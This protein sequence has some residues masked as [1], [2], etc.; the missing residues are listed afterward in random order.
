M[1]IGVPF[2]SSSRKITHLDIANNQD[3]PVFFVKLYEASKN[4]TVTSTQAKSLWDYLEQLSNKDVFQKGAFGLSD[5]PKILE[6]IMP[7]MRDAIIES[8]KV[9]GQILNNDNSKTSHELLFFV[10]AYFNEM[11]ILTPKDVLAFAT[12]SGIDFAK[13]IDTFEPRYMDVSKIKT[14]INKPVWNIIEWLKGMLRSNHL[15]VHDV[16]AT[17][18]G[19]TM[20]KLSFK[21]HGLCN[22][23]LKDFKEPNVPLEKVKEVAV[24]LSKQEGIPKENQKKLREALKQLETLE[25]NPPVGTIDIWTI[26]AIMRQMYFDEEID[27]N[28]ANTLVFQRTG[29]SLDDYFEQL[30]LVFSLIKTEIWLA[31]IAYASTPSLE[32]QTLMSYIAQYASI[33]MRGAWWWQRKADDDDK[34][35]GKKKDEGKGKEEATAE[36]LE[37]EKRKEA[38]RREEAEIAHL[39]HLVKLK[40]KREAAIEEVMRAD[41]DNPYNPELTNEV[42]IEE[43]RKRVKKRMDDALERIGDELMVLGQTKQL[44]ANSNMV[45]RINAGNVAIQQFKGSPEHRMAITEALTVVDQ[46]L[47][48]NEETINERLRPLRFEIDLYQAI[49]DT[50]DRRLESINTK[51]FRT[52]VRLGTIMILIAGVFYVLYFIRTSDVAWQKEVFTTLDKMKLAAEKTYTRGLIRMWENI[53]Q[54]SYERVRNNSLLGGYTPVSWIPE[55]NMSPDILKNVYEE[56][57]RRLST[58]VNE[59]PNPIDTTRESLLL[60]VNKYINFVTP[61]YQGLI[62]LK[63]ETLTHIA[64]LQQLGHSLENSA[65]LQKAQSLL[66]LIQEALSKYDDVLKLQS[67]KNISYDVI[68]KTVSLANNAFSTAIETLQVKMMTGSLPESVNLYTRVTSGLLQLPATTFHFCHSMIQTAIQKVQGLNPQ[69]YDLTPDRML[70]IV[71]AGR[72]PEWLENYQN[73]GKAVIAIG[74]ATAAIPLLAL[75]H[76]SNFISRLYHTGMDPTKLTNAAYFDAVSGLTILWVAVFEVLQRASVGNY[77][78]F[79]SF[80][81]GFVAILSFIFPSFGIWQ[82][83]TQKVREKIGAA[84]AVQRGEP[85]SLQPTPNATPQ[86]NQKPRSTPQ[87]NSE[88]TTVN[89]DIFNIPQQRR[90]EPATLNPAELQDATTRWLE[91]LRQQQQPQ[92]SARVYVIEDEEE[93]EKTEPEK[94]VESFVQCHIC[95]NEAR[96]MCSHCYDRSYCGADCGKIDWSFDQNKHLSLPK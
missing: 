16:F 63:A 33:G 9:L 76:V 64:K 32:R 77:A 89:P 7:L 31:I 73:V 3:I 85:Q 93:T 46:L 74:V 96:F 67:V 84:K 48:E 61:Y 43:T 95:G 69:P 25:K 42:V 87:L 83:V 35:K 49:L 26:A 72:S 94:K 75:F 79:W 2:S 57:L 23:F 71:G 28:T 54:S 41:P 80:G 68:M 6:Q 55:F 27:Q 58:F 24:N 70:Q 13:C 44:V 40:K 39:E 38:R 81:L 15:F 12:K 22:T 30:D 90:L 4:K 59:M 36:D 10:L 78:A 50:L 65:E 21:I 60:L 56:S 45:T 5:V 86:P 66:Q 52:S 1:R 37:L 51:I 91:S 92:S 11:A 29:K 19:T 34:D 88:P 47:T 20:Q 8:T 18:L 62:G 82:V 14:P 17:L 53:W